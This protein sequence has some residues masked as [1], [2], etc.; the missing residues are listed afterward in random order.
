MV[1]SVSTLT[2]FL[3]FLGLLGGCKLR[4]I[5]YPYKKYVSTEHL[6]DHPLGHPSS[7]DNLC[8]SSHVSWDQMWWLLVLT[9][10]LFCVSASCQIT[11]NQTLVCVH[12]SLY[13]GLVLFCVCSTHATNMPLQ[14]DHLK[15]SRS[16]L[17]CSQSSLTPHINHRTAIIKH[18]AGLIAISNHSVQHSAFQHMVG[19]VV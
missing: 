17:H 2:P 6:T 11:I 15:V 7:C 9:S 14:L 5:N 4:V 12:I 13:T 8:R 1:P 10:S 19:S 3:M 16:H 18:H